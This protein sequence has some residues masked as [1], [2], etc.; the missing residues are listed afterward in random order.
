MDTEVF[1]PLDLELAALAKKLWINFD[2]K[3]INSNIDLV[4]EGNHPELITGNSK[5][6]GCTLFD[7]KHQVTTPNSENKRIENQMHN[8]SIIKKVRRLM[9]QP[10]KMMVQ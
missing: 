2:P 7:Y 3:D 8:Q 5:G 6:I 4:I 10:L 9:H 1:Q